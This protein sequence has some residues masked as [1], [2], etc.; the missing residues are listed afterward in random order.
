MYRS[1]CRVAGPVLY[2]GADA[3]RARHEVC[4][5]SNP[6]RSALLVER[7]SDI[8]LRSTAYDE[9]PYMLI[10]ILGYILLRFR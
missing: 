9:P 1:I 3:C 6:F 7:W 8:L 2:I 4:Y 10:D 5:C